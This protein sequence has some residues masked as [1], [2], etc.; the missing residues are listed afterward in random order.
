MT[1]ILET[2]RKFGLAQNTCSFSVHPRLSRRCYAMQ[3]V[4]LYFAKRNEICTLQK[5]NL[6]FAK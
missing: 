5:E 2:E 4:L 6:Y 1:K 3:K